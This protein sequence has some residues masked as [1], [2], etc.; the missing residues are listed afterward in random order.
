MAY[1]HTGLIEP[2]LAL[3]LMH[4]TTIPPNIQCVVVSATGAALTEEEARQFDT[5]V[6]HDNPKS[7]E[8]YRNWVCFHSIREELGTYFVSCVGLWC[9]LGATDLLRDVSYDHKEQQHTLYTCD[10]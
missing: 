1:N 8:Q 4:S 7:K 10:I 6:M 2:L 9:R 3:I 5:F